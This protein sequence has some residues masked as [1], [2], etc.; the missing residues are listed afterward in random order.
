VYTISK[1]FV[2]PIKSLPGLPVDS[3]EIDELGPKQDRQMMLVDAESGVFVSQ[4]TLPLMSQFYLSDLGESWRVRFESHEV[5]FV[6]PNYAQCTESITVRV[7]DDEMEAQLMPA[8]ISDWFS[9]RL[10]R[11]LKLVYLHEDTIRQVDMDYAKAGDRTAFSDGFP[12]L[13]L[14]EMSLQDLSLKLGVEMVPERFRPNILVAGCPAYEEDRWVHFS[15]ENMKFDA[16]K[17]CSRCVVPSID[18]ANGVKQKEV[19]T[20]LVAHRK[21]GKGVYLGQNAIHRSKGF[22]RVGDRLD[23]VLGEHEYG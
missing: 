11:A 14:S 18:P 9:E 20:G 13:V 19:M 7:W 8:T 17:P 3:L 23:V 21:M 15:T 6:K 2:Y 10:G 22:I 1:L 4:R 5:D 12:L 16:V